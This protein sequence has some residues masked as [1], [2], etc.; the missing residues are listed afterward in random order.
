MSD[1]IRQADEPR[2]LNE[3]IATAAPQA[4]DT[5]TTGGNT[6]AILASSNRVVMKNG[7]LSGGRACALSARAASRGI[8]NR[9]PKL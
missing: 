1:R 3:L 8:L 2:N 9:M 6:L 5:V 4:H 7:R